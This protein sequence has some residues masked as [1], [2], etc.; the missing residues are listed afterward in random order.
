[1][2]G[3]HITHLLTL[4]I[5]FPYIFCDDGTTHVKQLFQAGDACTAPEG[6]WA[7]LPDGVRCGSVN[8]D[9]PSQW[10]V[11]VKGD[12]AP[13]FKCVDVLP[14]CK[15]AM[16][17]TPAPVTSPDPPTGAEGGTNR[18]PGPT[19]GQSPQPTDNGCVDMH[20]FCC[21]WAQ[22]GECDKNIYF[23]RVGCQKSCGTCGCR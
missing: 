14:T 10:C 18:L 11:I 9:W 20:P 19:S 21:Y 4:T 23:M 3:I 7:P 17:V 15:N 16:G 22:N 12:N 1:M 5:F 13:N 2:I 8:C 6:S